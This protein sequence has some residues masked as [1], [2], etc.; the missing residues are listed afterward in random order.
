MLAAATRERMAVTLV[1]DELSVLDVLARAARSWQFECQA[2][3]SAEQALNLL[4]RRRTP[5]L[6]TDLRM[7]GRG[8]L[9]L[10]REVQ[11]RWP[12]V[13]VIVITAGELESDTV[14]ECLRAGA[15]RYFLKPINLDEFRHAL[16]ASGRSCL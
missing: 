8:G 4:E 1:D 14:S 15:D 11:R 12:D 10:V 7:P 13:A 16:E 3:T 2:A 6:V 5:I 9:W